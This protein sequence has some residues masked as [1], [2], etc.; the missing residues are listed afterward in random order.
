MTE[1]QL[2]T[3]I[4]FMVSGIFGP[5]FWDAQVGQ[6]S[7]VTVELELLFVSRFLEFHVIE[8]V[9]TRAIDRKFQHKLDYC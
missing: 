9:T 3:M 7:G 6:N 4:I 2:G 8:F 1:V 5:N